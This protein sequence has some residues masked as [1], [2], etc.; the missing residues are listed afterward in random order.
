MTA[1]LDQLCRNKNNIVVNPPQIR[2]G[3]FKVGSC[4]KK[5]IDLTN[6]GKKP[7][8]LHAVKLQCDQQVCDFTFEIANPEG[9]GVLKTIEAGSSISI[10]VSLLN[11]LAT[12]V[13]YCLVSTFMGF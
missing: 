10:A 4:L 13:L 11:M 9:G 12:L 7:V 8:V 1:K 3:T 6:Q 2:F 5:N